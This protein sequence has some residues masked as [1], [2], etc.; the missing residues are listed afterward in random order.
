MAAKFTIW[1]VLLNPAF[2]L[3][4]IISIIVGITVALNTKKKEF[5]TACTQ[6]Q[7]NVTTAEANFAAAVIVAAASV[8]L[9]PV[10]DANQISTQNA[11][12]AAQA[13]A[14]NLPGCSSTC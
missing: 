11:L 10:A 4:V 14:C 6:A 8:G 9:D 2:I 12:V 13:A 3:L 5:A 7:A 1:S